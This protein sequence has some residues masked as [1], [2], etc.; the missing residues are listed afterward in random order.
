MSKIKLNPE[1]TTRTPE[2]IQTQLK[3]KLDSE[4]GRC[5]AAFLLAYHQ[6]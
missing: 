5:D 6:P 1:Q 4:I 2:L 3:E